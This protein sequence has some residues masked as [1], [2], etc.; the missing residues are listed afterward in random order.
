MGFPFRS[1]PKSTAPEAPD[2]PYRRAQQAW[3]A[4]MGAAMHAANGWRA[5]AIAASGLALVL[6]IG[7][8]VLA[9]Q[10]RTY[11]HVVE[12][13]PE[14]TVLSVRP[15]QAAYTPT[16]AQISYFLGQFVRQIRSV[17]T[18]PVVLRENWI[19]AYRY[20]AP[21]AAQTLNEEA[22]LDDPFSRNQRARSVSIRSIVQRSEKSWQVS[23]TEDS[24]SPGSGATAH[25]LYMGLF[26]IAVHA[27]RDSDSLA[28]NPLGIF[29]TDFSWS[30]ETGA[31]AAP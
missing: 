29:I 27:P 13:S 7:L 17:P 1:P 26:S 16:D 12:V 24:V 11:V 2:T 9:L 23:W 5:G 30:P 15:V 18:D 10:S 28:K 31:G 8:T 20:L 4:R 14:G 6:G 22:R 3:D 25:V 21:K 19:E